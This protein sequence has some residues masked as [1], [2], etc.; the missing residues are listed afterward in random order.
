MGQQIRGTFQMRINRRLGCCRKNDR[1][2]LFI[3]LVQNVQQ[4]ANVKLAF[5]KHRA[6]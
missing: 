6:S 5:R 1:T 3:G 4:W 2:M